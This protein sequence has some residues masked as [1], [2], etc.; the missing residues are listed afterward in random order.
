MESKAILFVWQDFFEIFYCCFGR[1]GRKTGFEI[2]STE[3]FLWCLA[4]LKYWAEVM[5]LLKL[6]IV[7][8]FFT[9]TTT[10]YIKHV[11]F[12]LF[13]RF[14]SY[15][16]QASTPPMAPVKCCRKVQGVQLKAWMALECSMKS[17]RGR[18][19]TREEGLWANNAYCSSALLIGPIH[20]CYNAKG[21][22]SVSFAGSS[23]YL[24]RVQTRLLPGTLPWQR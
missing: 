13:I 22:F 17:C 3:P 14:Y 24:Y 10:G 2:I 9:S 1:T 7:F 18:G 5:L 20:Y 6:R 12:C 11:S 4:W 23:S 8:F 21:Q 16:P 15:S 19:S